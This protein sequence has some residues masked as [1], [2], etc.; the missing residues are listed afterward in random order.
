MSEMLKIPCYF[1][2]S[3]LIFL[4]WFCTCFYGWTSSQ[5][6]LIG[7]RSTA[8]KNGLWKY[9]KKT[10]LLLLW[11]RSEFIIFLS[12]SP[13]DWFPSPTVSRFPRRS[14]STP[15][16]TL[17]AWR[18]PWSSNGATTPRTLRTWRSPTSCPTPSIR[19]KGAET[20]RRLPEATS[21]L[22]S[23]SCCSASK[24]MQGGPF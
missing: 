19:T 12:F 4:G 21:S 7:N 9:L 16:P 6:I 11:T 23:A 5:N 10:A 20:K 15:S 3:Q 18:N 24:R 2:S 1:W 13:L 17:A 14:A 8:L 22:A